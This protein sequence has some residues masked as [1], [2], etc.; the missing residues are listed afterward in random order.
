[1]ILGIDI[2]HENYLYIIPNGIYFGS[3]FLFATYMLSLTGQSNP[4]IIPKKDF[5]KPGTVFYR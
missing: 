3:P 2:C 4:V 1:M 5:L